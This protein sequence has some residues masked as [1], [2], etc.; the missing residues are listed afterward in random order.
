MN[1]K[2]LEEELEKDRKRRKSFKHVSRLRWKPEK[3]KQKII[4]D[5]VFKEYQKSGSLHPKK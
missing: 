3:E 4:H 1:R 5:K 2:E